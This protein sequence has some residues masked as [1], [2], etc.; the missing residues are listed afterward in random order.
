[1]QKGYTLIELMVVMIIFFTLAAF[2]TTN[3]TSAQHNTSFATSLSTLTAD[4][5]N[6]QIEAMTGDTE[7][8]ST[9][10]YYG[11]H[12]DTT[13]YTLFHGTTYNAGD[14]TN[15]T[16]P[17]DSTLQFTNITLT[18]NNVIFIPVSGEMYGYSNVSNAVTLYDIVSKE[19]KT[20]LFNYLG[21]IT[22]D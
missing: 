6:E 11:V 15:E 16:I 2:V 9:R 19:Q 8:R 10:D 1:M 20:I 17:L 7:G 14:T 5:K 13:S 4:I 22:S 18:N 12:F 3:L 21:V